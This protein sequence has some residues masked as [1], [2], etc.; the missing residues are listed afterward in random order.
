[1]LEV[2]V[3]IRPESD[4]TAN[5]LEVPVVSLYNIERCEFDFGKPMPNCVGK[6]LTLRLLSHKGLQLQE[7]C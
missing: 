3:V 2:C 6:T 1:L 5:F 7:W 4:V